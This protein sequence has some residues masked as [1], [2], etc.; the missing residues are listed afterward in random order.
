MN[1]RTNIADTTKECDLDKNSSC[2]RTHEW[3][4]I[5]KSELNANKEDGTGSFE[6]K[7]SRTTCSISKRIGIARF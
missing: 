1:S 4:S 7:V 6:I 3:F 2:E 5:I